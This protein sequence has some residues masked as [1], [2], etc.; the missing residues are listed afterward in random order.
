MDA[1]S[2][3]KS[4]ANKFREAARK[5]ET[6]E[7]EERFGERLKQTAK[8]PPPLSDAPKNDRPGL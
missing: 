1:A 8:S 7:S 3:K 4:Q 2:E 6:D 5:L